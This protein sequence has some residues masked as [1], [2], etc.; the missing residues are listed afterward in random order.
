ML[1]VSNAGTPPPLCSGPLVLGIL[2]SVLSF[3]KTI[4]SGEPWLVVSAKDLSV[5]QTK[6]KPKQNKNDHISHLFIMIM[7]TVCIGTEHTKAKTA[8][9]DAFEAKADA[10]CAA[11]PVSTQHCIP[12]LSFR[13]TITISDLFPFL[14]PISR[15]TVSR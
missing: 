7:G 13:A 4:P 2:K 6:P 8:A 9:A 15:I 5:F 11:V 3:R 10:G 12:Q 14:N 1:L